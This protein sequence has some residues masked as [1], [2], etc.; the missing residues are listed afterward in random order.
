MQLIVKNNMIIDH[1]NDNEKV[2][3]KY[4][5]CC[6]I[7]VDNDLKISYNQ[8]K[9]LKKIPSPN[10][11]IISSGKSKTTINVSPIDNSNENSKYFEIKYYPVNQLHIKYFISKEYHTSRKQIDLNLVITKNKNRTELHIRKDLEIYASLIR[12]EKEISGCKWNNWDVH[13]DRE[14]QSKISTCYFMA[15]SGGGPESFLWKF[16]H[17]FETITKDQ[18]IDLG[19]TVLSFV[20][21]IYDKEAEL[22]RQINLSLEINQFKNID[23]S[24]LY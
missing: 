4:P 15:L 7:Y 1:Y 18:M 20:Q 16:K 22:K 19:N 3:D 14:S 2:I 21:D 13:T 17:G 8:V 9:Q 10:L 6:N 24:I 11:S 23:F 5:D 12:W